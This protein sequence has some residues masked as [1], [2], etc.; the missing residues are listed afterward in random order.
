MNCP[1]GKYR[2]GTCSGTINAY[3]CRGK[4]GRIWGIVGGRGLLSFALLCWCIAIARMKRREY[5]CVNTCK[6]VCVRIC[7]HV[8][9]IEDSSHLSRS[10]HQCFCPHCSTDCT[11]ITNAD[12]GAKYTCSSASDT[13][14]ASGTCAHGFKTITAVT[15]GHADR[16]EGWLS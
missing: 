7:L 16:C 4:T 2:T 8:P 15:S 6:F 14:F 1:A 3:S 9:C 13:Q 11:P 10:D 12:V 5:F